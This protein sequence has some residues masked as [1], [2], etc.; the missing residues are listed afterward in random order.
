LDGY[1]TAVLL[2]GH[3]DCPPIVALTANAMRTDREKCLEAGC[4]AYAS[5]P[6]NRKALLE[7]IA[8]QMPRAAR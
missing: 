6:I 3:A 1:E 2:K 4:D 7:T 5:K 8:E